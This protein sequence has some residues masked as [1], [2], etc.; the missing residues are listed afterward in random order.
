RDLFH[1]EGN[2]DW[3]QVLSEA[4]SLSLFADKKILEVRITTGKPGDKGSKALQ[5]YCA[6]PGDNNLLLVIT[7]KLDGSALRSKWVKAIDSIGGIIQVWP[8]DARQMP[9]WIS[10]RLSAAGIRANSAAIDILADR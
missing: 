3:Q 8:V 7:P 2:F 6:N 5:E 10:Q 4:S 1:A 9:R